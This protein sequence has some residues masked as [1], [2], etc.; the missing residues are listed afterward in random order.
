[1]YANATG[2]VEKKCYYHS[3]RLAL[4][5]SLMNPDGAN[6]CGRCH[7]L[8]KAR[9]DTGIDFYYI[10]V[11]EGLTV[12]KELYPM[13]GVI[14]HKGEIVRKAK[15]MIRNE[16]KNRDLIVNVAHVLVYKAYGKLY[17]GETVSA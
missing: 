1:V 11:A 14:N 4:D 2:T 6:E 17:I 16:R 3:M 5:G 8:Q 15:R 7:D 13:F 9:G 10:I 12:E